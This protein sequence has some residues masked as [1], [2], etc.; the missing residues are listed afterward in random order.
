MDAISAIF[1]SHAIKAYTELNHQNIPHNLDRFYRPADYVSVGFSVGPGITV[2]L[3]L[4]WHRGRKAQRL[5]IPYEEDWGLAQKHGKELVSQANSRIASRH[6]A[7]ILLK[8]PFQLQSQLRFTG[9][10]LTIWDALKLGDELER[11]AGLFANGG[12]ASLLAH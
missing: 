7:P 6:L 4:P 5:F 2:T 8:L 10:S 3:W 12:R 9:V 1:S 11:I